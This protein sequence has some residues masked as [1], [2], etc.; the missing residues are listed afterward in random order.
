MAH[1]LMKDEDK[2]EADLTIAAQLVPNDA[3]IRGELEK[4]LL[5]KKEQKEKEKRAYRKMFGWISYWTVK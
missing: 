1:L 2:A 5:A 4:I 3:A